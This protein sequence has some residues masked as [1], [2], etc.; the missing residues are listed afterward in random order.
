MTIPQGAWVRNGFSGGAPR[1]TAR[2]HRP[3]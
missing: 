3:P 2:A 1:R